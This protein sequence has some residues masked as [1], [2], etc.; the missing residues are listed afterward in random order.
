MGR[1]QEGHRRLFA[2][3]VASEETA[4]AHRSRAWHRLPRSNWFRI[5]CGRRFTATGARSTSTRGR[6]IMALF[7][8]T[9]R[10]TRHKFSAHVRPAWMARELGRCAGRVR[11]RARARVSGADGP[12]LRLSS[13]VGRIGDDREW[14][15]R[16]RWTVAGSPQG[17][18]TGPTGGIHECDDTARLRGQDVRVF[19]DFLDRCGKPSQGAH[20]VPLRFGFELAGTVRA[21]SEAV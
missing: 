11:Q 19:F 16:R 5:T 3:V 17:A 18:A 13:S 15:T 2:D 1:A 4:R 7:G 20:S 9:I 12:E 6:P 21:R 8:A 14:L 10:P